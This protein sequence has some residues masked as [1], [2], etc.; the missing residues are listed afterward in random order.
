MAENVAKVCAEASVPYIIHL[1]S[2]SARLA[3][4][5]AANSRLYGQRKLEAEHAF[6]SQCA[7]NSAVINLR[8]PA[9]YGEG[10][11]GPLSAMISL[12]RMGIPLPFARAREQRDYISINN[13][14]DLVWSIIKQQ[15]SCNSNSGVKEYEPCDGLPLAT[16]E[17]TKLIANSL[18]RRAI[19]FPVP[20]ALISSILKLLGKAELADGAFG[21]LKARG[22]FELKRDFGW[23]PIETMPESL[24]FLRSSTK[25]Q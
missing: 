15:L 6:N 7:D 4:E 10:M 21:Y 25:L 11:G 12:V 23:A 5:G 3:Q 1:S 13:L 22:N 8:P 16:N 20:I 17:L 24:E 19:Q 14:V 18:G 2:I 9:V